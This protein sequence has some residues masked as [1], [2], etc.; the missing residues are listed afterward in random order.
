MADAADKR[1]EASPAM[2]VFSHSSWQK[3]DPVPEQE[4]CYLGGP[5][6]V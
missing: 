4:H 1:R 2:S 6:F 3:L 5:P